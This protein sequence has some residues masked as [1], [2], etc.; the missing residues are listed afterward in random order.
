MLKKA[1]PAIEAVG[2]D[3]DLKILDIACKKIKMQSLDIVLNH[4]TAVEL[5]YPEGCFDRV[6]SSMMLH[7]LTRPD[8]IRAV[9][10]VFRVLK[11][12]GEVHIADFGKPRSLLMQLPASIIKHLEK[13]SDNIEG[14]IPEILHHIGFEQIRENSQLM[15]IFGP[16][17]LYEAHK[18]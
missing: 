14:L 18:S 17:T 7:H 13:A 3:F 15:T 10:E 6:V 16:V 1:C 2:L 8:K 4:G 11:P 5:P 12:Q 9:R